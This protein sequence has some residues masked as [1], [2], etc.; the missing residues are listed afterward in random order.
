MTA[1]LKSEPYKSSIILL[2]RIVAKTTVLITGG[3]GPT[4]Q[5]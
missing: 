3:A 5:T 1:S 4:I 2:G